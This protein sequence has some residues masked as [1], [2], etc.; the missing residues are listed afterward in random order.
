ML[1]RHARLGI[2]IVGAVAGGGRRIHAIVGAVA[3]GGRRI[4]AIVGAVAGGGRRI[5]TIIGAHAGGEAVGDYG[6]IHTS[7]TESFLGQFS[8]VA[9]EFT[10]GAAEHGLALVGQDVLLVHENNPQLCYL[11]Y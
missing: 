4:H 7:T 5:H 6:G 3:E 8:Q 2:T 9:G 11:A 1:L 10:V